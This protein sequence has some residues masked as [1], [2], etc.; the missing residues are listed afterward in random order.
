MPGERKWLKREIREGE[1]KRTVPLPKGIDASKIVARFNN[2]ILEVRLD[3]PK[4][5]E[6]KMVEIEI[7]KKKKKQKEGEKKEKKPEKKEKKEKK[8]KE[9]KKEKKEKK[10]KE[11]K[12]EHKEELTRMHPAGEVKIEEEKVEKIGHHG[13]KKAPGEAELLEGEEA[14]RKVLE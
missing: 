2:G 14:Q 5:Q 4:R 13:Q 1:F 12:K 3:K 8:E 11:E 7:S 9:E 6:E 10:E